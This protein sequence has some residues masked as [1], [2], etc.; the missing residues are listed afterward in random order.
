[1]AHTS[2]DWHNWRKGRSGEQDHGNSYL[3]TQ[4][5]GSRHDHCEGRNDYKVS[6]YNEKEWTLPQFGPDFSISQPQTNCA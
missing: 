1:M 4:P 5:E 6:N 2:E 3:A